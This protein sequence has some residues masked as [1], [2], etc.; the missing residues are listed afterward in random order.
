[1]KQETMKKAENN[2]SNESKVFLSTNRQAKKIKEKNMELPEERDHGKGSIFRM[3][4]PGKQ[5]T[6]RQKPLK[7]ISTKQ[8]DGDSARFTSRMKKERGEKRGTH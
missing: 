4:R 1:M 2:G 3:K 8:N 6:N 7:E 5:L